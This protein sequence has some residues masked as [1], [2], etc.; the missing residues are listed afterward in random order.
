MFFSKLDHDYTFDYTF[1]QL[2]VYNIPYFSNYGSETVR[3][4]VYVKN[5]IGL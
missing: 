1:K 3:Y 4:F 5:W 2:P